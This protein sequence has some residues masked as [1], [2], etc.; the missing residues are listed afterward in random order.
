LLLEIEI[1]QYNSRKRLR[2]SDQSYKQVIASLQLV[3]VNIRYEA[4]KKRVKRASLELEI[5]AKDLSEQSV[6]SSLSSP[7]LTSK[8]MSETTTDE[9]QL[10]KTPELQFSFHGG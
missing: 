8:D 4:M 7:S 6:G 3:G 10:L 5:R 2:K 9:H 1:C